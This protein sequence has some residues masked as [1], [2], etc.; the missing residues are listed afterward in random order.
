MSSPYERTASAAYE[1]LLNV[2]DMPII[3]YNTLLIDEDYMH[4]LNSVHDISSDQKYL[5]DALI[6]ET[7]GIVP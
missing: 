1:K 3:K 6:A 2:T 5:K 4:C 7:S